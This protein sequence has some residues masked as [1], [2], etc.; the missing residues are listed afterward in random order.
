MTR[1][2]IIVRD[3]RDGRDAISCWNAGAESLYGW[4]R[5]EVLGL[6]L[7]DLLYANATNLADIPDELE[8]TGYWQGE[9]HHTCRDG[10]EV[11][12]DSRWSLQRDAH[13]APMAILQINADVTEQKRAEEALNKSRAELSHM[14][15]VMTLG[16]LASS[17]AHEVRQPIAAVVTDGDSCLRWLLRDVPDLLEV[18][19]CVERMIA[20]A[21][22]TDQVVTRLRALATKDKAERTLFDIN[23]IVND[24][25]PL[26]ER[27]RLSG[28]VVLDLALDPAM[29]MVEADR[30][31]LQQVLLNLVVNAIQAM[32]EVTDRQRQLTI[33]SWRQWRAEVE[34]ECAIIE[35]RDSGPGINSDAATR[36]FTPFFTTKAQGMGMG[37]SISRSIVDAHGGWIGV[38]SDQGSGTT[39]TVAIPLHGAEDP[40]DGV[41]VSGF[42]AEHVD[43]AEEVARL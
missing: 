5:A 35:V 8:R 34:A 3:V 14:T 20:N 21:R 23:E 11:I 40:S 12:V 32:V 22:R 30:I 29:M 24:I 19:A 31:Q 16:E 38:T 33:H 1:D 13:G 18:R 27:E 43:R 7:Q 28:A 4:T 41:S 25:L 15:R 37:L 2:A 10:S 6:R 42:V 39:F 36:L 9:L 17:I 26:V